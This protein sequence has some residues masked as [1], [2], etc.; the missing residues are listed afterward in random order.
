LGDL[1]ERDVEA[2]A[3]INR[4]SIRQY[5]ETLNLQTVSLIAID[6]VWSALRLKLF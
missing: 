4:D 1:S 2:K 5:A 3:D 6:D